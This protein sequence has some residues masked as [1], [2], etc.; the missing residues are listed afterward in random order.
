MLILDRLRVAITASWSLVPGISSI[1]FTASKL[2]YKSKSSILEVLLTVL[3]GV[4][5]NRLGTKS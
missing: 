2:S 1:R 3:V 5:T 4:D